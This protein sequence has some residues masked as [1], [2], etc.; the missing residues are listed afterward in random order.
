MLPNFKLRF[1]VDKAKLRIK[2]I[3]F[4]A[5]AGAKLPRWRAADRLGG[6]Y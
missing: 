3:W 1:H 2:D 5:K 6:A 4:P